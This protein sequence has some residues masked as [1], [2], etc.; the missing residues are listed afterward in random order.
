[1]TEATIIQTEL[2]YNVIQQTSYAWI[3]N[4][5]EIMGQRSK[6][7]MN[8]YNRAA[9]AAAEVSCFSYITPLVNLE[10]FPAKFKEEYNSIIYHANK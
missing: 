2:L 5:Y 6:Y 1:M 3:K 7:Y 8:K 4:D 9:A 10:V